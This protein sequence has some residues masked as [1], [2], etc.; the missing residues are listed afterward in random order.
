MKQKLLKYLPDIITQ[1]GILVLGYN[2]LPVCTQYQIGNTCESYGRVW[3][4]MF[5]SIGLNI[6]LRRYLSHKKNHNARHKL[7][8]DTPQR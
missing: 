4:L 8:G 1:F 2:V 3:G 5:I 6:A 7:S